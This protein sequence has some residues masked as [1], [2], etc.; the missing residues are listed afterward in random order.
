MPPAPPI[1]ANGPQQ[2][3][4]ARVQREA[5]SST[6]APRLVHVGVG[7]LDADDVVDPAQLGQQVGLEVDHAAGRDVV[8]QHGQVGG[9]R[10]G[11]RSAPRSPRRFGLL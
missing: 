5:G 3:V 4:V 1:S 9:G 7:L 10:D 2:V 8:E 6:I 11:A